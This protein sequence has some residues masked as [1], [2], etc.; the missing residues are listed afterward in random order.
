MT[1]SLS[2]FVFKINFWVKVLYTQLLP[3]TI[4]KYILNC[5][6]HL[7]ILIWSLVL[8]IYHIIY[9]K[10]F[11]CHS[12]RFP[13]HFIFF[14]YPCFQGYL[15]ISGCF[16][17]SLIFLT[18]YSLKLNFNEMPQ[19]RKYISLCCRFWCWKTILKIVKIS[20]VG[21][22]IKGGRHRKRKM[23]DGRGRR[24]RRVLGVWGSWMWVWWQFL[25]VFFLTQLCLNWEF[26]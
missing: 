15:F 7:L 8:I 4:L 10:Q 21:Y 22:N 11:W 26:W 24:S 6:L 5:H 9:S 25:L 3:K 2:W 20:V 14:F 16:T 23:E 13:H 1:I 18:Q 12:T 19:T 17:R